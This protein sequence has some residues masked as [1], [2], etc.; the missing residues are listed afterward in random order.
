MTNNTMEFVVKAR[1]SS[2]KNAFDTSDVSAMK[3]DYITVELPEHEDP[4][5]Y[6]ASLIVKRDRRISDGNGPAG[7]MDITSTTY[8]ILEEVKDD[9]RV[10]LFFGWAH[11]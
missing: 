6:A 7:C 2:P 3:P 1:G 4:Y 11:Y 9:E 8:G 10:F 5:D